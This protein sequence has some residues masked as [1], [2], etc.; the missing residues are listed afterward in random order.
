M[1]QVVIQFTVGRNPVVIFLAVETRYASGMSTTAPG[2]LPEITDSTRQ[3]LTLLLRRGPMARAELARRLGLS[4][5]ALTKLTRPLVDI[6]LLIEVRNVGRATAG[7]PA[8]PLAINP[9]WGRFVGIKVTGDRLY[10]VLA[11]LCGT[12]LRTREMPLA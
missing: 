8:M 10:A 12:A 11:N 9:E 6:G 5:P 3:A 4:P 1:P 7:R 2:S